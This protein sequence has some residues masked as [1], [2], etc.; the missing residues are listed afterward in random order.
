MTGQA[1]FLLIIIVANFK[2]LS[3]ANSY[4]FL[5]VLSL[6]LSIGIGILT[7]YILGILDLGLLEHTFGR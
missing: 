4:S 3:F 5:M 1:I 7:W 2:V 6:T